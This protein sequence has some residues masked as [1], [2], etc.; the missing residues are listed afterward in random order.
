MVGHKLN[1]NI[2]VFPFERPFILNTSIHYYSLTKTCVLTSN[3]L[4]TDYLNSTQNLSGQF[5]PFYI[6]DFHSFY[7]SYV[8]YVISGDQ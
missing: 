4:T 5:Y 2:Y 6:Q 7:F 8:L 1:K 3:R